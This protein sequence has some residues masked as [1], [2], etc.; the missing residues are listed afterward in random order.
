MSPLK[1]KASR[2]EPLVTQKEFVGS[3]RAIKQEFDQVREKIEAT[4]TGITN[5]IDASEERIK[6]H[7]DLVAEN[8]HRDVGGANQ[9]EISLIKDQQ[10]HHGRRITVVEKRLGIAK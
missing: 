9:D 4:T 8:I 6:R 10:R 2:T 7:F 3:M 1:K 5:Y